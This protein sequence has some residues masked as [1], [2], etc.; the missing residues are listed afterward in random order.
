MEAEKLAFDKFF[1]DQVNW[2]KD[3]TSAPIMEEGRIRI[4]QGTTEVLRRLLAN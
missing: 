2:P 4:G 3:T 1:E